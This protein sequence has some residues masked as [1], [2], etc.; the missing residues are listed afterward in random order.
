MSKPRAA[1]HRYSIR[2]IGGRWRGRRLA[3]PPGTEVRPTPDRVRETVF[4]WLA[5]SIVRAECLDLFAGTGALGFEALSRGALNTW[6]IEREPVLAQA[7]RTRITALQ[8]QARVLQTDVQAYLSK[9]AHKQFDVV[10]LDAP[11]S[12]PI[13]P[14]L[15]LLA[16]WLA[17]SATIYLERPYTRGTQPALETLAAELPGSTLVKHSRAG[18]VVFG[19]LS[20]QRP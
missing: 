16:P 15:R 1:N 19:L 5:S 10:F 8:A 9:S 4:N 11:Y 17:D 18:G 14:S 20:Y 6:F 12:A 13:E 2:I 7:L 3:I